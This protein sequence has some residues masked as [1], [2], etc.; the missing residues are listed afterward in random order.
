MTTISLDG[1]NHAN[2]FLRD[3][4][5]GV[6]FAPPYRESGADLR[7]WSLPE[8]FLCKKCSSRL[9]SRGLGSYLKHGTPI[10]SSGTVER[11]PCYT[12]GGAA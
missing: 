3:V 11:R 1:K 10:W 2:G 8:C 6:A 4:A 7:G 12:C 5:D 9:I